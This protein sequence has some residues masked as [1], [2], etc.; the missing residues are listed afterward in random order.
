MLNAE[1]I[2][3][4]RRL[5]YP[6]CLQD[7]DIEGAIEWVLLELKEVYPVMIFGFFNLVACQQVYDLFNPVPDVATS[8]GV[9]PGGQRVY[10]V[11]VPSS[12]L[13][14]DQNIFGIAP[15][16]QGG[17][18]VFPGLP[19]FGADYSF[20]T[21][22]DWII[23]DADWAA[24]A[25]RFT[26]NAFEQTSDLDGAPVRVFPVPQDACAAFIRYTRF[27]TEQELRQEN[28]SAFFT[29]VEARSCDTL[30]NKFYL[31]AGISFGDLLRDDGRTAAHFEKEAQ[32]KY[33][34][35]WSKFDSLRNEQISPVQRS[36]GP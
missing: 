33:A 21:P 34:E 13:T 20:N 29:L 14:G 22:G 15:Y 8:Q 25:H 28:E 32:R 16:L 36:H 18:L 30:A 3:R 10:E 35:G 24:V 7:D 31:G 9:F 4:I 27:R 12:S 2:A 23:W 5:G 1:I 11:L 26:P 19:N 17:L 6:T